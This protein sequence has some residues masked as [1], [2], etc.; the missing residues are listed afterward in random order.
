MKSCSF[1]LLSILL[2]LVAGGCKAPA[3]V[4]TPTAEP[5]STPEPWQRLN[6]ER[7]GLSLEIPRG[8]IMAESNLRA[9]PS[10]SAATADGKCADYTITNISGAFQLS[11]LPQ[12]GY[13]DWALGAVPEGAVI[14]REKPN[15]DFI[16]RYLEPGRA[17]YVYTNAN[18]AVIED[19]ESS[20]QES[21]C[22]IPPVVSIGEGERPLLLV[23]E[24]KVSRLSTD[25]DAELS[26][27]DRI[28]SS[29]REERTESGE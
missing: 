2:L 22:A 15:H 13:A 4:P 14:V 17:L 11:I 7:Y 27:A 21:F 8:W 6:I 20:A 24:L 3:P 16:I 26:T 23:I 25:L 12:C 29:L 10:G 9:S 28:V 18:I 1:A 19:D 5:T